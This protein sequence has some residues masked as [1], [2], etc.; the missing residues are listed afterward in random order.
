MY[1][2]WSR[3]FL[4]MERLLAKAVL[5]GTSRRTGSVSF[6]RRQAV[7]RNA[8]GANQDHVR[9]LVAFAPGLIPSAWLGA[10]M[11]QTRALLETWCPYVLGLPLAVPCN[12]E[13]GI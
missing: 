10:A 6:P 7:R 11:W 5:K 12:L 1:A 2:E 4:G 13:S 3:S 8:S 9:D